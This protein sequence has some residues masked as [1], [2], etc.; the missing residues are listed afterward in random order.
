MGN[1]NNGAARRC[2]AIVTEFLY[3]LKAY[4]TSH[5]SRWAG[6]G[7]QLDANKLNILPA[8]VVG[9]RVQGKQAAGHPKAMPKGAQAEA[10]CPPPFIPCCTPCSFENYAEKRMSAWHHPSL[11]ILVKDTDLISERSFNSVA[12]LVY[13]WGAAA[14][15]RQGRAA[16]GCDRAALS[17]LRCGCLVGRQQ[18]SSWVR[19]GRGQRGGWGGRSQGGTSRGISKSVA[20]A[21]LSA[22]CRHVEPPA[23]KCRQRRT[24]AAGAFRTS[25]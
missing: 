1:N 13:R 4:L 11:N 7:S 25:A 22:A 23:P 14:G 9:P 24:T 5:T 12:E 20:K 17:A 3:N 15:V 21:Q 16:L 19:C 2:R 10:P 6:Y 18:A 8:A